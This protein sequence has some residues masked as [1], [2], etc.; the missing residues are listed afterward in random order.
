MSAAAFDLEK[1]LGFYGSYHN[2]KWNII[3]HVI[4]VPLILWSAFAIFSYLGPIS[5]ILNWGAPY[6]ELNISLIAAVGYA[7]YYAYLE[8]V[9]GGSMALIVILLYIHANYFVHVSSSAL[10]TAVIVHIVGWVLQILAHKYFEGRAPSLLDSLFQSLVLAPLFVWFEVL[11]YFGYRKDL[12]K[13]LSAQIEKNIK[14]YR[15][16]LSAIKK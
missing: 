4:C 10:S 9:A 13:R 7:L 12:Y 14:V 16:S 11:F 3:T 8:R 5:S 1:Q 2:N 15:D 6:F